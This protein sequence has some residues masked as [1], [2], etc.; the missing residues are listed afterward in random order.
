MKLYVKSAEDSSLV[1][2]FDIIRKLTLIL[3]VRLLLPCGYLDGTQVSHN[4]QNM[5]QALAR[6]DARE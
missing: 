1:M 2:R 3:I 4:L 5:K 6:L